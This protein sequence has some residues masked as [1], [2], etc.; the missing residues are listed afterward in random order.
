[1]PFRKDT[2]DKDDSP[3]EMSSDDDAENL[4]RDLSDEVDDD[5][6]DMAPLDFGNDSLDVLQKMQEQDEC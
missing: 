2:D 1:M 5:A 3:H 6:I 4:D